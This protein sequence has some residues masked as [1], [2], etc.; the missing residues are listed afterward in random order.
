MNLLST[1]S[2]AFQNWFCHQLFQGLPGRRLEEAPQTGLQEGE[3][4]ERTGAKG[5][6]GHSYARQSLDTT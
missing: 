6:K 1:L 2:T 4:K 5:R 3:R